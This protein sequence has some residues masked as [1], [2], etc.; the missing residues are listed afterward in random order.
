MSK[1]TLL[2]LHAFPLTPLMWEPLRR[3]LEMETL[4]P[5]LDGFDGTLVPEVE[6]SLRVFAEGVLAKMDDSGLESAVIGGCSMGGYV[7]MELLRIA[8]DRINGL[9]LC[10]TKHLADPEAGRANRERIAVEVLTGGVEAVAEEL[11]APLLGATT[12]RESPL[13]AERVAGLIRSANPEAVAW[14]QRAMALRPDS[15]DDLSGFNKPALVLAGD[16][17]SLAP[18]SVQEEMSGLLPIGELAVIPQAGHL[19]V[20]ESPEVSAEAIN[21]WWSRSFTG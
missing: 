15:S 4:A 11:M 17:D 20:W 10:D 1:P 12:L 21:R 9:L 18:V 6:P 13:L 19:A 3:H 2:L 7:A 14:A 8:P 5:A 16:E